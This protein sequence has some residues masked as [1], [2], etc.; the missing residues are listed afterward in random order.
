MS[1]PADKLASLTGFDGTRPRKIY[2]MQIPLF[3]IDA[4]TDRA[5]SGNPAAVCF[6]DFWFDD[7]SLRKV[8]AENNLPATVFL[9]ATNE[10]YELRWFSPVCEL[11]LC[12]H[13]TL[14]AGFVLFNFLRPELEQVHFST[15][16][17]GSLTVRKIDNRI[18]MEFPAIAATSCAPI[19]ELL[20][21]LQPSLHAAD[22]VDLFEGNQTYAVFLDSQRKV[23]NFRPDFAALEKLH[24]KTVVITAPGNDNDFVSR[25]FAPAYGIPE[26]LVTGSS[27]CLLAPIWAKRL[28]K[29]RLHARQLSSRPGKLL[30]ELKGDRVFLEGNAVP[31]LRGSMSL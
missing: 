16:F 4:F 19:L 10:G 6:L 14:A 11:Q 2:V 13:A 29:T 28:G 21:A 26:D 30:C 5:L 9:V 12:G 24:P 20:T 7:G 18:L 15:R 25:Y 8:A 22:I 17:R 3:Q 1:Y 27:H 31:I 23:A